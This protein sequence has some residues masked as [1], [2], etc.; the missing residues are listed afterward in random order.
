M[1]ER[2]KMLIKDYVNNNKVYR[3]SSEEHDRKRRRFNSRRK[4]LRKEWEE[5]THQVWPKYKEDVYVNGKLY[6]MKGQYYDAHHII[7]ISFVMGKK[8]QQ[9]IGENL[10]KK[11]TSAR[12]SLTIP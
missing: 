4:A 3:I 8:W 5:K 1:T 11:Q 10:Q 9:K 7:E 6:R 2:Q 12:R